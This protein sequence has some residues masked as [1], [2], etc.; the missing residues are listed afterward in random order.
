MLSKET[1]QKMTDYFFWGG[2]PEK[3]YELVSNMTEWQ[4]FEASVLDI[5]NGSLAYEIMCRS[6][7]SVWQEHVPPPLSEDYPTYRGEIKLPEHI[8]I[9]GGK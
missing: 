8:V 9:R 4:Q 6:D 7:L 2:E 5:N 1:V 3:A